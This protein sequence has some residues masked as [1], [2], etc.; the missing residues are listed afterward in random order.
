MSRTPL[1]PL[2]RVLHA[3]EQGQNPDTIERENIRLR[4]EAMRD[5][6]RILAEG[7]LVVLAVLFLVFFRRS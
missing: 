7:R 4:H 2:A 5:R 3:R 6:V 1:R